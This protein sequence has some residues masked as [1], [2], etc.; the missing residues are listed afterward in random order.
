MNFVGLAVVFKKAKTS[1][2]RKFRH[3]V[4]ALQFLPE[5]AGP[6]AQGRLA[7]SEKLGPASAPAT[8]HG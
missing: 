5:K 1:A 8:V 2:G 4:I 6:E 7:P 3:R